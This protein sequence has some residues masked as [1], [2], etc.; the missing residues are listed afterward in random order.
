MIT[1]IKK[2]FRVLSRTIRVLI[3]IA[4][5]LIII[6]FWHKALHNPMTATSTRLYTNILFYNFF[7]QANETRIEI[8]GIDGSTSLEATSPSNFQFVSDQTT[9]EALLPFEKF[10]SPY[11]LKLTPQNNK[12]ICFNSDNVELYVSSDRPITLTIYRNTG[13][14]IFG[15]V[16]ATF[17]TIFSGLAIFYLLKFKRRKPTTT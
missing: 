15:C 14:I 17:I 12:L 6:V 13:T 11:Y 5:I 9:Y 7:P 16:I 4:L 3:S 1:F 10:K 2:V 8:K